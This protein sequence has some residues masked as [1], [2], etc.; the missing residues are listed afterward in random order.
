MAIDIIVAMIYLIRRLLYW[1][2][3]ELGIAPL[4]IGCFFFFSVQIL[5]FVILSEYVLSILDFV[6]FRQYVVEKERINFEE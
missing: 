3:F 4:I 2:T 1:N 6:N 5:F